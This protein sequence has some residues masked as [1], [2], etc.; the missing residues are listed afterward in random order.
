MPTRHQSGTLV[1]SESAQLSAHGAE[2]LPPTCVLFLN[3]AAG[4]FVLR[5]ERHNDRLRGYRAET[6]RPELLGPGPPAQSAKPA[7]RSRTVRL[8]IPRR[9]LAAVL[10]FCGWVWLRLCCVVFVVAS[11]ER[12]RL[13]RGLCPCAEGNP[14]PVR[15][16]KTDA[17]AQ[18]GA[19]SRE[20]R[21]GERHRRAVPNAAKTRVLR[22]RF[23][24]RR[25]QAAMFATE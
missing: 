15:H 23:F 9:N 16:C 20:G 4:R 5:I 19:S 17:N 18:R 24:L 11:P 10:L 22:E 2:G 1:N 13:V 21:G 12:L 6:N 14:R 3:P 25:W 8:P 7:L